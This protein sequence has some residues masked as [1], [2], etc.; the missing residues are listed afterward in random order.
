[1]TTRWSVKW[2][3]GIMWHNCQPLLFFTRREARAFIQ[4]HYG[5]IKTREDLRRPP[6]NW[7]LP[8]AVRVTVDIKEKQCF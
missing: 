2:H 1:M 4:E 7:R 3:P 5:Y 8:T 6:H